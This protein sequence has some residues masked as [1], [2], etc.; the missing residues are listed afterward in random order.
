M[1]QLPD[2]SD[3]LI[4]QIA[5]RINDVARNIDA[6]C[7][8]YSRPR[9]AV[10]I[11]GV[12][13]TKPAAAIAAAAAAGIADIGENYL[14]EA[15]QKIETLA[16]ERINWHFIGR[17]QSNKTREIAGLFD[18]VHTVA[19]AKVARRLNDQ[20]PDGQAP[21]R[22]CLQ[23]NVS[24]DPAKAGVQPG[25]LGHLIE[26][27]LPLANLQL[28][29]LMTMPTAATT[30]A[31]QRAPFRELAELLARHRDSFGLPRFTELS[32]GMSSDLEAAVAEGATLVRIG[33]AI[34]GPREVQDAETT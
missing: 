6:L 23:V 25:G 2:T 19:S 13:K 34:F 20:R 33:T 28:R 5:G 11:I 4:T 15:H 16:S 27:V 26:A 1:T 22:I 9:D 8:R 17:I 10:R 3:P 31:A 12:S 29:G 18:W 14:Q 21:L 30:L 32:M 24:D 7:N